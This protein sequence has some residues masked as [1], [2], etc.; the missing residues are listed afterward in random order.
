MTDK[1]TSNTEIEESSEGNWWQLLGILYAGRRF[2]IQ[3]TAGMAVVSVVISLLLPNWYKASSR[4]L[5]SES[6]GGGIASALLGDLGSAAKSLLGGSG[7]DYVRY[8]AI[9]NSRSVQTQIIEE[10]DLINVYDYADSDFPIDLTLKSLA[11]NVEFVIDDEFDFLSVEVLDRDA[12]RAADMSNAY[13]KLLDEVNNKL[14]TQT[15][16]NFREYVESRYLKAQEDRANMLDSLA[17]FQRK[18]GVVDLEAQ[19]EA[20]FGQLA[21]LR[22]STLQYEIQLDALKAQFGENNKQVQTMQ[23]FVDAADKSFQG[24]LEGREI[25]MPVSREQAPEMV[26]QYLNLTMERMIQEKILEFVAPMLE[27][28]RFEEERKVEALQVVDAA[29]KPY[30]KAK[31]KRM[32]IVIAATLSAFILAIIFL[33][34]MDWWRRN[35]A[36]FAARLRASSER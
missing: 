35:S 12:Q 27:Q 9:L 7:G 10:F 20:Y 33:L 23:T 36:S 22:A 16:G 2:I 14:T 26:R 18:Y 34:V 1:N 8:L 6:S 28:A 19:T 13:V 31:P 29:V 21:E 30:K 24:A 11:D 5:L 25:V 17:D 4:L 32:I 3:V 15:A